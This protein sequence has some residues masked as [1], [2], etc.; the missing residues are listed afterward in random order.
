ML[1]ESEREGKASGRA[2]AQIKISMT[3]TISESQRD[4][5]SHVFAAR[6]SMIDSRSERAF[7]Q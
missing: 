7:K 6:S 4:M 5:Y 1:Y 2:K 3:A